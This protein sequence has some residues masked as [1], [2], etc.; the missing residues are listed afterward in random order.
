MPIHEFTCQ[1]CNSVFELLLMSKAE[2]AE[3]R[4][5]LC[6]SPDVQRLISASNVSVADGNRRI[7][8]LSPAKTIQ[9]RTCGSNSCASFELR[10]HKND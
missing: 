3:V 9:Q 5:P 1:S 6:Q 8:Q 2:I 4:C 10:G 7:G